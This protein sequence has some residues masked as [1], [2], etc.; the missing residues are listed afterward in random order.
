MADSIEEGLFFY[1]ALKLLESPSFHQLSQCC[2]QRQRFPPNEIGIYP[3][4]SLNLRTEETIFEF[5]AA[6]A[7]T[8]GN[9]QNLIKVDDFQ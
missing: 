2:T 7:A 5:S 8:P 4:S 1:Q 6:L 9:R 3:D